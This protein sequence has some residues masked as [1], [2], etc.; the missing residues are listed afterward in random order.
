MIK[1][2]LNKGPIYTEIQ[3]PQ[4]LHDSMGMHGKKNTAAYLLIR[5]SGVDLELSLYSQLEC[6]CSHTNSFNSR[7]RQ[8]G[9]KRGRDPLEDFR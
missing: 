9:G 6:L 7:K 1:A 3:T 4:T 5:L 2:G 8:N